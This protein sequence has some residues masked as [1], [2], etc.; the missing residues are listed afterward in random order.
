MSNLDSGHHIH[1]Q[2]HAYASLNSPNLYSEFGIWAIW[3]QGSYCLANSLSFSITLNQTERQI[4]EKKREMFYGA[5][6]ELNQSLK[7]LI[8]MNN[9]WGILPT[10]YL[11]FEWKPI[12]L[13]L[14]RKNNIILLYFTFQLSF[15]HSWLNFEDKI[16]LQAFPI[17]SFFH[18]YF[19][20]SRGSGKLTRTMQFRIHV[21]KKFGI[22]IQLTS[23][24]ASLGKKDISTVF[25][26]L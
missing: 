19:V 17:H 24:C 26:G 4:R 14:W 5:E 20:S 10:F 9:F 11:L 16:T 7:N 25:L 22:A 18:S 2:L 21:C 8:Q 23:F 12:S 13:P 1:I 3:W 6:W 15:I